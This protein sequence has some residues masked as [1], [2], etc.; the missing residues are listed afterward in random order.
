M[1]VYVDSLTNHTHQSPITAEVKAKHQ[2]AAMDMSL[3]RIS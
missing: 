1:A 2:G 3:P